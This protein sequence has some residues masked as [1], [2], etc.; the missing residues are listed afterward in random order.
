M[1]VKININNTNINV[2]SP[3]GITDAAFLEY[4]QAAYIAHHLHIKQ[5]EN[6]N[7]GSVIFP[8]GKSYTI[9]LKT[10]VIFEENK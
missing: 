6:T 3:N 2:E 8:D 5:I 10:E 1:T 9:K 4:L 7:Y